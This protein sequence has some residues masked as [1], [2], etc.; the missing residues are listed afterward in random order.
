MIAAVMLTGDKSPTLGRDT[1]FSVMMIVLNGLLGLTLL[2]G[3]LK[4]KEQ[5]YNLQGA[6]A[7]VG[8][9]LP[10]AGLG[11][12]LPRFMTSAPGGGSNRNRP[13]SR[14]RPRRSS[15]VP[16]AVASCRNVTPGVTN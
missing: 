11:L 6:S 4:Y 3:A 10:M 1:L 16:H 13:S 9:L 15:S 12:I 7:Y 5:S 8:V 2:I 14:S